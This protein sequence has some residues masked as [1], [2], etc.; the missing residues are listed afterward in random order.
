MYKLDIMKKSNLLLIAICLLI[1]I[2]LFAGGGKV[3]FSKSPI[4]IASGENLPEATFDVGDKIYFHV[5]LPK[6]ISEYKTRYGPSN[7]FGVEI[8]ID[9]KSMGT[10]IVRNMAADVSNFGFILNQDLENQSSV[11]DDLADVFNKLEQGT[12]NVMVKIC[13]DDPDFKTMA[14]GKFTLNK[15]SNVKL[16]LGKSFKDFVAKMN[17]PT[18]EANTLKYFQ[19]TF[20]EKKGGDYF[21]REGETYLKTKIMASDWTILRHPNTGVITGREI[22]VAVLIKNAD[23]ECVVKRWYL[24][25]SYTGSG[26]QSS[27]QIGQTLP[28]DRITKVDCE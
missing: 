20:S 13:I 3:V 16:K 27:F 25:Q 22:E 28:N 24:E 4:D 23:G 19:T 11:N 17:D 12:H 1:N 8:I 18:L 15:S 5:Y 26:Y 10:R 2:N 7:S 6:K 21:A 14:Q 9:K